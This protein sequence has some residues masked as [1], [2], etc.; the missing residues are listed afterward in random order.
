M[1]RLEPVRGVPYLVFHD[2]YQYLEAHYGR[3]GIGALTAGHDDV[4][5]VRRIAA[6]REA[7][8]RLGVRCLFR[9]PQFA[10]ALVDTVLEGSEVRLG[11]LD[12]LGAR[13]QPGPD[14]YFRMMESNASALV[15]CL[16]H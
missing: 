4:P 3:A 6:L 11:V 12:P 15:S 2:A 13:F 10:S 9:E 16:S 5:S 8:Q 7:V 1:A 14:A